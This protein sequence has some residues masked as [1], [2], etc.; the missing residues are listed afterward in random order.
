LTERENVEPVEKGEN[1]T[2]RSILF[3]RVVFLRHP[4]LIQSIQIS[5]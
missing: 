2:R 1:A 5:V 3:R 4:L